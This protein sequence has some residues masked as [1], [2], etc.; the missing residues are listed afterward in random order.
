MGAGTHWRLVTAFYSEWSRGRA[1]WGRCG[2]RVGAV[3]GGGL[4][5]H[6]RPARFSGPQQWGCGRCGR[7]WGGRG[8]WGA[9]SGG[10]R[11]RV[12]WGVGGGGGGHALEACNNF[13]STALSGT[14]YRGRAGWGRWGRWGRRGFGHALEACTIRT[15]YVPLVLR[16]KHRVKSDDGVPQLNSCFRCIMIRRLSPFLR[17]RR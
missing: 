8:G 17:S 1:G 16:M 13:L 3:G 10:S 7:G 11:G 6:W 2:R 14:Q 15:F 4:G 5:T 9:V 12:G